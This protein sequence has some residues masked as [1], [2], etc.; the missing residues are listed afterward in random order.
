MRAYLLLITVFTL[1]ASAQ[2]RTFSDDTRQMYDGVK[3]NILR[4][5][6]KVPEEHY[7]FKPTDDV[8][9]IGQLLGHIADANFNICSAA[10][11]TDR[12]RSTIEKTSKTR[13]E[14]VKGLQ[15]SFEYCDAVYKTMTDEKGA[16][17]TKFF[18]G[19]RT[20]LGILNFNAFHDME[21][22]GNLVTYMRLK[23][24]VPPSSEPRQNR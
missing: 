8:R 19:E 7:S 11:G 1:T 10:S 6:E 16:E 23:G 13:S 15:E 9:T 5:A 14:T 22:Y 3:R 4:T 17:V 21:H 2:K 24:I 12:P 18:G 20:R